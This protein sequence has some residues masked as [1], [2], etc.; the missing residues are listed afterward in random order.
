MFLSVSYQALAV[1]AVLGRIASA[2]EAQQSSTASMPEAALHSAG[3]QSKWRI[4]SPLSNF[5][6]K[7]GEKILRN[8]SL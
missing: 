5:K 7:E 2:L 6:R 3:G 8:Y 4:T 1:L